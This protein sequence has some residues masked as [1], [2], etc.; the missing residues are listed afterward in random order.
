MTFNLRRL[1]RASFPRYYHMFVNNLDV[2]LNTPRR[3]RK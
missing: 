3:I 1:Y 2:F